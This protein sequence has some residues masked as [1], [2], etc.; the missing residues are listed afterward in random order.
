MADRP[1]IQFANELMR[2]TDDL[3]QA[4]ADFVQ[5]V[6]NACREAGAAEAGGEAT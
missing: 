6:Y 4:A 1:L 2:L 5:R 3:K